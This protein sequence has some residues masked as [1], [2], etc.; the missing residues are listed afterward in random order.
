MEALRKLNALLGR[1]DKQFLLAL[2]F[3]S[4][5]ISL[6]ETIGIS[7]IMP[8]ISVASDFSTIHSNSYF[9]KIYTW[10]GFSKESDFV[11][12]FGIVLI[13]FYL[14]RSAA[15]LV[16][17]YLLAR[18]SKG[19]YHL[20][21]YRLFENY[22]GMPYGHFIA[23]NSSELSKAII[24]EAQNLTQLI[25]SILFMFSE[26]FIVLLIYGMFLYVNWKITLLLTLILALNAL[27]MTQTIS[28]IIKRQGISREAFQRR[29]YE[30][31]NQVFGNFKMIKLRGNEE[32]IMERFAEASYG[33][34]RANIIH[35]TLTHFPR[36]FLEAIGFSMIAFIVVYMVYKYQTDIAGTLGLLSMFVL[37]LYRLM[38]SVNRILSSYN[39]ILFY[40]RSLDI[41][42]NDLFYEVEDLGDEPI[43][44][45]R[46]ILLDDIWFAYEEGKPVLRGIDL[47]IC[48]GEKIGIVGESGSGK[49]TLVDLL[50]GLYRPQKGKILVDGVELDERNIKSWRRKIGYIPQNIYLFDGTVAEN[51]AM[52]EPI[53]E[54]RI[55]EVLEQ[56][57]IWDFLEKQHR[58]IH[59]QVGEGGLKL[60]GGQK[61]RI[62]IARALYTD[63]EI[64]VLDE[65]TSALDGETE[66][67][68]M[69]EIYRIG[70]QKTLVII[71]HRHSTLEGCGTIYE[72]EAGRVRGKNK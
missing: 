8:F 47:K 14:F 30:V 67:E 42:H 27:F 72:L 48:K 69:K 17:F 61:Q 66:E 12:A 50:I 23:R 64:L 63:P 60:S 26:V 45:R 6:I 49:S 43:E 29:F 21:A 31:I 54:Q 38:P 55:I 24:N 28:K 9:Q 7:A 35:E 46:E 71:A 18:F 58:G 40:R 52:N 53:D 1:R 3:F 10:L 36:L 25:S 51:V 15:N 22:V 68:I 2:L 59:T 57:R 16:Y 19:R 33:F 44:F 56:A 32:K 70:R 4:V 13:G 11:I 34:A 5:V 65:A 20:I 37:G 39:Q 62:A 41:V